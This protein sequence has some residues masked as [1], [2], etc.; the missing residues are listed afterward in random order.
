MK[1]RHA[2][3]LACVLQVL[4]ATGN[5]LLVADADSAQAQAH[6]QGPMLALAVAPNGAFVAGYSEA[7]RLLVWTADFTKVLSEFDT[8]AQ[9]APRGLAWCGT[10]S[11]VV[12]LE[13]GHWCVLCLADWHRPCAAQA[14]STPSAKSG[15]AVDLSSGGLHAQQGCNHVI[16]SECIQLEA[17]SGLPFD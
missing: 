12:G 15:E 3:H 1:S 10:D 2:G 6:D 8:G 5:H 14:V 13:V 7:G 9:G 4:V 17:L 11:V 16:R